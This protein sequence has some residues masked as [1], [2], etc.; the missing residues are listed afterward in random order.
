MDKIRKGCKDY[1]NKSQALASDLSS[2]LVMPAR[3][4]CTTKGHHPGLSLIQIRIAARKGGKT[5]CSA[6]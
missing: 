4:A 6:Y 1:S 3:G 2:G 5:A